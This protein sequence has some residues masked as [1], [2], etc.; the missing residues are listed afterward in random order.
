MLVKLGKHFFK[1]TTDRVGKSN[2]KIVLTLPMQSVRFGGGPLG[3]ELPNILFIVIKI[4]ANQT[5]E[6]P[7]ENFDEALSQS[8]RNT[9][10]RKR[11]KV[12]VT[13]CIR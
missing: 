8:S 12:D 3:F 11:H 6:T 10:T 7:K 2:Y 9:N 13:V 1:P 5:T 4:E